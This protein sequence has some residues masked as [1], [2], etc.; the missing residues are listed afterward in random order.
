MKK[1]IIAIIA[2][3]IIAVGAYIGVGFYRIEHVTNETGQTLI[4]RQTQ[5]EELLSENA[6]DFN[7]VVDMIIADDADHNDYYYDE[8]DTITASNAFTALCDN[9]NVVW[10]R[11]NYD[12]TQVTFYQTAHLKYNGTITEYSGTVLLGYVCTI[13]ESGA[14]VWSVTDEFPD[15]NYEKSFASALY[16]LVF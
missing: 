7:S 14:K 12:R 3:A 5:A 4:T 15:L 8:I 13:D 2:A 11:T 10:A 6:A 9:C 16:T 1:A